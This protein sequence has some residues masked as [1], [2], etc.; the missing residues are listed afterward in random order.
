MYCTEMD[1]HSNCIFVVLASRNIS[2]LN[3]LKILNFKS[4]QLLTKVLGLTLITPQIADNF[5]R[6]KFIKEIINP[7]T[8][9]QTGL[10]DLEK[11]SHATVPVTNLTIR[12]SGRILASLKVVFWYNLTS[13]TTYIQMVYNVSLTVKRPLQ[14]RKYSGKKI[15]YY[16]CLSV[17]KMCGS[18]QVKYG[19]SAC[20]DVLAR[21]KY[22]YSS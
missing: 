9:S 8:L 22:G 5:F 16:F 12:S 1:K 19:Y 2:T 3:W 17:E 11:I 18:S 4:H 21:G 15:Y 13:D 10:K 6:P 14:N 20:T 7:R